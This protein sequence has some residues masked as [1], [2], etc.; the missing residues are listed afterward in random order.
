MSLPRNLGHP[1][2]VA[3][4]SQHPKDI[5]NRIPGS[6]PGWLGHENHFRP[7]EC[8]RGDGCLMKTGPPWCGPGM[9]ARGLPPRAWNFGTKKGLASDGLIMIP[10]WATDLQPPPPTRALSQRP[11]VTSGRRWRHSQVQWAHGYTPS[12]GGRSS[13]PRRVMAAG[14][15]RGPSRGSPPCARRL[16]WSKSEVQLGTRKIQGGR[17]NGIPGWTVEKATPRWGHAL[18]TVG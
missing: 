5:I 12:H 8:Q 16:R 11:S 3:K 15:T 10:T 4:L 18:E 13:H 2:M 9:T 1:E 17:A 6:L 7:C 14:F